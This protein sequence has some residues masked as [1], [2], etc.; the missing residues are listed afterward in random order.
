MA[1]GYAATPTVTKPRQ[2]GTAGRTWEPCHGEQKPPL[3]CVTKA[4][5]WT[6]TH[7]GRKKR[8]YDAPPRTPYQRLLDT[9]VVDGKSRTRLGHEHM[10]L[11][12][13]CITRR[14]DQIQQQLIELASAHTQGI[15]PAA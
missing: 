11:N 2:N 15:R 7:V 6:T 10:D 9:H 13:A 1:T 3:P 12:S 14:T 4:T 8:I 5:G